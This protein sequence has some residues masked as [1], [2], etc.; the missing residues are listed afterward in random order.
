MLLTLS[1]HGFDPKSDLKPG[2]Q[3]NIAIDVPTKKENLR[4][5]R[6]Y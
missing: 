1:Q 4:P 6:G 5:A 2:L 3:N